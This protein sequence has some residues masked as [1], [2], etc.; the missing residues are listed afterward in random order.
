MSIQS[1]TSA[2]FQR[3][4]NSLNVKHR[5]PK[6]AVVL[7][8]SNGCP[9]C[10]TLAPKY[11]QLARNLAGR[12]IEFAQLETSTDQTIG[13]MASGTATEIQFVPMV[14]LYQPNGVPVGV[15]KGQHEEMAMAN[16]LK[17]L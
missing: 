1:L 16:W 11:Q 10:H 3:V 4:G 13:Q 6:Y 17:N 9:H 5:G 7:F 8:Y 2:N 14:V 12:N 15:Y